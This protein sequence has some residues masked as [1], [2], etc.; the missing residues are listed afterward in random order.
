[1]GLSSNVA[2]GGSYTTVRN[3]I[4]EYTNDNIPWLTDRV[5]Y[6]TIENVLFRYNDWFQ[7][8]TGGGVTA[9]GASS[10]YFYNVMGASVWRY[11]TV[12]NV[13]SGGINAGT[14]SLTEYCRFEN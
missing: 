7:G 9:S 8:N 2:E 12:E 13:F 3:C 4:F 6:P 1:M 14:N 11:V 5:M 10:N